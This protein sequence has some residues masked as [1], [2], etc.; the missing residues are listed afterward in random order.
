MITISRILC[1]ID[2]SSTSVHAAELAT[3]LAKWY[4]SRITALHVL[5]P[6]VTPYP[7]LL[8]VDSR[9]DPT[10][11]EV[12]R[13]RLCGEAARTFAAA[14]EAGIPVGVMAVLKLRK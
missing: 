11:E 3:H 4:G 6:H 7:G 8:T 10:L 12:E 14:R 2:F 1:P 5:P 13:R 9:P